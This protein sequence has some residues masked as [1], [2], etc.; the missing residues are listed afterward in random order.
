MRLRKH[1]LPADQQAPKGPHKGVQVPKH[2][3]VAR[4]LPERG[5]AA[6]LPSRLPGRG[7]GR[8]NSRG[9]VGVTAGRRL[10]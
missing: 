2:L 3:A 7:L 1:R 6:S 10:L 8:L 9:G 4:T 5:S